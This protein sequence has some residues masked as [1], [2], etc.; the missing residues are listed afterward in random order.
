MFYEAGTNLITHKNLPYD[1]GIRRIYL[2]TDGNP[3]IKDKEHGK[4]IHDMLQYILI[5]QYYSD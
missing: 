3:N 1:D 2:Y 5:F 4:R